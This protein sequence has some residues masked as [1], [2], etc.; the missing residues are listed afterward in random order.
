MELEETLER[1]RDNPTVLEVLS[2][3][4][5]GSFLMS[6]M[7]NTRAQVYRSTFNSLCS[8][9]GKTI[10]NMD[11]NDDLKFLRMRTN[12]TEIII[13]P[14]QLATLTIIQAVEP[15]EPPYRAP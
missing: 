15:Y 10:K 4:H 5:A 7:D 1:I 6:T 2:F 3:D 14:E 11:P 12:E 13:A 8:V 9:A